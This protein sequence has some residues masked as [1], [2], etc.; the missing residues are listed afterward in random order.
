MNKLKLRIYDKANKRMLYS[1]EPEEQGKRE[2]YPFVFAVGWS[3][4]TQEQLSE[5]M[6]YTGL[7]DAKG[8][9]MYVGDYVRWSDRTHE[10]R[11][12]NEHGWIMK[13]DRDD[14]DCPGLYARELVNKRGFTWVEVV[15]NIYEHSELAGGTTDV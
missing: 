6:L 15:G 11:W 5:P 3:H 9:E 14:W 13:D 12:S 7:R 8:V 2:Y 1:H 10:I 4:W